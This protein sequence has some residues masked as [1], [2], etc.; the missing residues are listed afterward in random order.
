MLDTWSAR[1]SGASEN[2][3]VRGAMIAFT[4]LLRHW[5][6]LVRHGADRRPAMEIAQWRYGAYDPNVPA[7]PFM[8]VWHVVAAAARGK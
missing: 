5:R 8:D 3:F 2:D 6:I 7:S 1:R 4:F